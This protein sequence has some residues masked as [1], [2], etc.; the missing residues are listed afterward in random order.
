ML[1]YRLQNPEG[2]K[3]SVNAQLQADM[4]EGEEYELTKDGDLILED[5]E[6]DIDYED[7]SLGF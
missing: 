4:Q 5:E 2:E 3:D 7:S 1:K 6:I